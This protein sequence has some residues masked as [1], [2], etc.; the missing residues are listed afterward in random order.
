[1][2]VRSMG[3]EDLLEEVRK[4]KKKTRTQGHRGGKQHGV[5]GEPQAAQYKQRVKYDAWRDEQ[6]MMMTRKHITR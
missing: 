1:M 2:Q 4:R 6:V 3:R 5:R